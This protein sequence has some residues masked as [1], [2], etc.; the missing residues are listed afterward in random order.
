MYYLPLRYFCESITRSETA[1]EDIVSESFIK[2]WQMPEKPQDTAKVKPLLYKMVRNGAID[3]LRQQ[4]SFQTRN[5]NIRIISSISERSITD[6]MIEAETYHQLHLLINSLPVKCRQV[7]QLFY[8]AD[9]SIKEIAEELNISV[10]TV[11]SH[12]Q[13]AIQLIKNQWTSVFLIWLLQTF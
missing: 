5:E 4:Q 12:K 2:L 1:S 8:F 6:K 7:F 10:N 13:K 3:Y 9:M 11:K